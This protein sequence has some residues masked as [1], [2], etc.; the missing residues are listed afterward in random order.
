MKI[1]DLQD[2]KPVDEISVRIIWDNS[3]VEEKFGKKIKSVLV[4]DSDTEKGPTAY[5]DL[6]NEYTKIF[7]HMDKIKVT[8]GFSKLIQNPHKTQ[9]RIVNIKKIERIE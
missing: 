2:H 5:L 9:Y 8:D 3:Q 4:A 1:A 7:K 6:Y